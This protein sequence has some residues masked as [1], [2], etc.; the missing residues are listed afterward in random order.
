MNSSFNSHI[1]F[2][3]IPTVSESL[4]KA[5]TIKLDIFWQSS[6]VKNN[7]QSVNLFETFGEEH[8]YNIKEGESP[9]ILGLPLH[10]TSCSSKL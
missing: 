10:S 9:S 8:M 6:N 5:A 1:I 7:G 3:V 2:G 4:Y